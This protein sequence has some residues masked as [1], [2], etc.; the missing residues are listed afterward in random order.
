MRQTP[1]VIALSLSCL[2]FATSVHAKWCPY[3]ATLL[4]A[5][6]FSE[7]F[8]RWA[9]EESHQK[10]CKAVVY[11]STGLFFT[12]RVWSLINTGSGD[13]CDHETD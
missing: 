8:C 4:V 1:L 12:E 10:M 9:P 7:I 11:G 5:G 3:T 6:A 2:F 13:E